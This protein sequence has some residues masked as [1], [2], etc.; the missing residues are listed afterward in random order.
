MARSESHEFRTVTG[1]AFTIH[2]RCFG[3]DVNKLNSFLKEYRKEVEDILFNLK[4]EKFD[5]RLG[6]KGMAR[7]I[8]RTESSSL[9]GVQAHAREIKVFSKYL[10]LIRPEMVF[11]TVDFPAPFA[12]I[13]VTISPA[14][15]SKAT[16]F[17]A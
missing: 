15:T 14:F 10:G 4:G 1:R 12:P 7:E 5:R 3:K 17:K 13:K 16:C 11:R 9:E 8:L 2:L 6:I